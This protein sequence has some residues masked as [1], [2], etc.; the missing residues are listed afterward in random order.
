MN[1]DMYTMAETFPDE[2]PSFN[3]M[4]KAP[5]RGDR[6]LAGTMIS[7]VRIYDRALSAEEIAR[8]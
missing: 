5:F 3:W 4:G 6:Y 7:D 2:A 1:A 8:L